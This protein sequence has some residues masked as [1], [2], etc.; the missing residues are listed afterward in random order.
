MSDQP[1]PGRPLKRE[2]DPASSH[3][4]MRITRQQKAAYVRAAVAEQKKLSEW[5]TEKLDKEAR[6]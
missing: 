4:H 3:L 6:P 1:N 2:G 5:V